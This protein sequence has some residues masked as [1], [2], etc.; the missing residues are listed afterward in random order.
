MFR[1]S[2]QGLHF[3]TTGQDDLSAEEQEDGN[4]A[5]AYDIQHFFC[6]WP[7]RKT[8]IHFKQTRK[9]GQS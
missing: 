5:A 6:H 1:S 8:D 2:P 4:K 3:E 9:N 7:V